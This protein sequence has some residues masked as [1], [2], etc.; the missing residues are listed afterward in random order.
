MAEADQA[1]LNS[2]WMPESCAAIARHRRMRRR[3]D[4][5]QP[6]G[7]ADDGIPN[8]PA[9]SLTLSIMPLALSSVAI[10]RIVHGSAI[11]VARAQARD[12]EKVAA[13]I[14][15]LRCV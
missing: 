8:T 7:A 11:T 3:T 12:E 14:L 1:K 13:S 10:V 4:A 9:A 5:V 15:R 6:R 2:A